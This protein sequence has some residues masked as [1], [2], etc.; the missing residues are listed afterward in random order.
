MLLFLK[1]FSAADKIK[2]GVLVEIVWV[3]LDLYI[4]ALTNGEFHDSKISAAFSVF[5]LRLIMGDGYF[6][7]LH[8]QLSG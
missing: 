5:L 4:C 7:P 6:F 3:I 2:V 8:I 1:G